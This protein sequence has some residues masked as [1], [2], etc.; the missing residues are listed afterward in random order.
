MS[1]KR[2][3]LI[4]D[5][6]KFLAT[7]Q[8]TLGPYGVE[9]HVV[10]D[11]SDG[12]ARAADLKPAALIVAVEL[13]EKFGYAI[14]NKAKKGVAKNIPVVMVTQTV[15]PGDLEQ[16]RKLKVHAD[17]YL[18]KRTLRDDDLVSRLD[19]LIGLPAPVD[20]AVDD[21]ELPV[22]TDDIAFE[23][24]AIAIDD[25]SLELHDSGYDKEEQTRVGSPVDPGI[26]AETDAVFAG[27]VDGEED[28]LPDAGP[29]GVTE[30]PS[31]RLEAA[32][33]DRTDPPALEAVPEPI[34][35]PSLDLGMEQ[36]GDDDLG[37]SPR[38][39][40]LEAE[41]ARVKQQLE[42]SK[43]RSGATASSFTREREFLNLREVI[44]RKEKELIELK[45]ELDTKDRQTLAQKDKVRELERRLRDTDER[46]LTFEGNLVNAQEQIQ[47]LQQDKEK[48]TERE[49]GLKARIEIAQSQLRKADEDFEAL[50]K[51]TA[52][53]AAQ[54][55]QEL[56]GR[57]ADLEREK[58]E[59]KDLL[60]SLET[61]HATTLK[62]AQE[63]RLATI[64][65]LTQQLTEEK[66]AAIS[67]LR[68]ELTEENERLKAE[69]AAL[70]AGLR[71]DHAQKLSVLQGAHEDALARAAKE[72]QDALFAAEERRK[73]E[74]A[75][76]EERRKS[77]LSAQM[78]ELEGR[79]QTEVAMKQREMDDR[80]ARAAEE[81]ARKA[82]DEASLH[83]AAIAT[84]KGEHEQATQRAEAAAEE[85]RKR[86][87]GELLVA[88]E[89]RRRKELG[90]AADKAAKELAAT[91]AAHAAAVDKLT[92][93][94]QAIRTS[95]EG[96]LA[97]LGQ[98][99]SQT[100]D[101]V[102]SLEGEL[103]RTAASLRDQEARGHKLDKDVAERDTRIT[104]LR[105]DLA[106]LE[107]DHGHTTDQL[108]RANARIKSD[109]AVVAKAKRAM[110]VALTLLDGEPQ[111]GNGQVAEK[112]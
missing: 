77:E 82:A 3:L 86:E 76:A 9:I 83:A 99:L 103:G 33:A 43:H 88:E 81:A 70:L 106:Q 102:K 60:A 79:R 95:L 17:E 78:A 41:L 38:V 6:P 108:L 31:S 96:D 16:H 24:E 13:P 68:A 101:N 91:N 63:E 5:D 89:E 64:R 36:I 46:L 87:R 75:A 4:D 40:E 21:M 51:R 53:E 65:A 56:Q 112:S 97:N 69:S 27:L 84:L 30:V 62:Q 57:R 37:G 50:K 80:L 15:P 35:D 39:Q 54:L 110:A 94:H 61:S 26:D 25:G 32:R 66:D 8:R 18:D 22:E 90:E 47:A 34:P 10:D 71:N 104:G 23:E 44:N 42:E 85:R 107:R 29:T 74:V 52:A 105:A 92:A 93:E 14:C 100:R 1:D 111:P 2:L 49:R 73:S 109:E 58:K 28:P 72:K 55:G 98:T 45:E 48:A 12:L 11:G 67:H 7:L 59:S 19:A 20:V